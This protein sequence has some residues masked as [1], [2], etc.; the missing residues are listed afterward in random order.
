[1]FIYE[2]TG[3]PVPQ[4]QTRFVCACRKGHAYDPSRKDLEQMQWQMRP[5]APETPLQGPV[6]LTMI[7]FFPIPKATSAIRRRQMINRVILPIVR[8]DEDN[9]AYIVTNA[10]KKI[11]YEDDSQICAKHVYKFYG[12]QPKTVVRVVPIATGENFGL[13]LPE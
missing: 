5:F 11:F 6:E 13:G 9:L 8:P 3:K 10:M 7:F 4:K 2:L 1:M 12:A